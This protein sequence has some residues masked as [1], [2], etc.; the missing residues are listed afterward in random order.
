M[1]WQKRHRKFNCNVHTS[2][3][4]L[5]IIACHFDGSCWIVEFSMVRTKPIKLALSFINKGTW[6]RFDRFRIQFWKQ[7][8]MLD[9]FWVTSWHQNIK[10]N[11]VPLFNY[12][13][14]LEVVQKLFKSLR[15]LNAYIVHVELACVTN[16]N[17][18]K[19]DGLI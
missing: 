8:W 17:K 7:L 19:Y 11:K 4:L 9:C 10:V 18:K 12:E 13:W 3:L 16:L 6:R 15:Y 1:Q 2:T 14:P 5:E